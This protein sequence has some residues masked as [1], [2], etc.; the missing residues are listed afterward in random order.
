MLDDVL[1]TLLVSD[2]NFKQ[3][4]AAWLGSKFIESK[5]AM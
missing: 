2:F 4:T 1:W 3:L 5:F